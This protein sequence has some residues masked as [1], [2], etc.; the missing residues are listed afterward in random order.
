VGQNLPFVAQKLDRMIL[1]LR[2]LDKN[3]GLA[4]SPFVFEFV[5]TPCPIH[6]VFVSCDEWVH[7]QLLTH[8]KFFV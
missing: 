1:L 8:P 6:R 3:G 4:H 5:K 7:R 2:G